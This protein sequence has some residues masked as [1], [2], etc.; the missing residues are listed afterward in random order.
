MKIAQIVSLQESVPPQSK[1]GLE[2]V[3]S[4]LTEELVKRGHK[5]TLFAPSNSKTKAKLVSI[6]PYGITNKEMLVWGWDRRDFSEW[7]TALAVS[8]ENN[9]DIIHAHIGTIFK[10]LPFVSKPVV[11]TTHEPYNDEF[12]LRYLEKKEY[13]RYF[14]FA[15]KQYKKVYYV[16]ISKRQEKH[17]KQAQKYYFKKHITIYNGVPVKKFSFNLKP[18]NYLLYLGY[19]NQKKGADLAAWIAKKL[20]AKLILAGENFGQEKFFRQKIKPYLNKD[21]KYVGPV[22]FKEKNDLYKNALATL[23]PLRWDEPFGLTIVESQACGTPVIAFNK[24][25]APE[26]IQNGKTGFVV[27]TE[28]EMMEAIKKIDKIDRHQC[29]LWV[30]NNFTVEKMVDEYEKLY[31]QLIKIK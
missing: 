18:K 3:V 10:F 26:L 30:E 1:N 15:L 21:I 23:A 5:I 7:N 28:K 16:N 12:R 9:F 6:F 19:I 11:Y 20:K 17:F 4:W 22:N 24:G 31:K 13:R 29:R 14:K 8:N 25:A 27:K 2:F